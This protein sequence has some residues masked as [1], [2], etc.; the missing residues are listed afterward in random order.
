M[1]QLLL[2][3][4]C[5]HFWPWIGSSAQELDPNGKNVCKATSLSAGLVCCPGWK[6]EGRECTAALC[7]REDACKVD[8]VCVRP[9]ICLCKPGFFG[10][11]CNSRC[12]DQ[13]W[14][15]DCKKS[16]SCHPN[17]KCDPVSGQCTCNANRWGVLCEFP[18]QCAPHGHCNPHSGACHCEPGWWGPNCKKQCLCRVTGS[19]CDPVTGQCVCTQG[20]WGRRCSF[21]CTCH[22]SPCA[23]DS[24]KCECRAGFWGPL[25][26]HHC[27][28][29]HGNCN[30]LDGH[31]SCNP[32]YQGRSCGDPCPAGYYGSQCR[33]SCGHCKRSQPCSPVDGFCLACD[34]GWNGTLCK[35]L[36][37][38][39]Y[40]G[41]NCAQMCPSCRK[42]ETCHPETGAC[43]NC[44]PGK[45]GP[46]CEASCPAGTFGDGCQ[47]TCPDCVNGSCDPVS[48]ECIC[49][50]GYWG[51]SCNETCPEGLF[52]ANC[53][54]FCQCPRGP[55]H[56]HSGDCVLRLKHQGALIAG[57]LIPLLLLL[58]CVTCC[59]CCCGTSQLDAR[60]RMAVADGDA[61]SRMKHHVQGVLAN[62]SSMLPCFSL[63][64]YKLPRVTVSHHDT[65][66][67]FNPSF[68]EP[69]S[70]AWAS[71]SSF[72]SSFDTDDEDPAYCVP[73]RE[74]VPAVAGFELQ[75]GSSKCH[76][77]PDASAFNSEDV[78][79]PFTIPRTS[80]IARA[81]R[82]SVSFAE[83]TKFGPQCQR[84]SM[85]TPNT[86]RKP[87]A[88]CG[89]TKLPPRQHLA[90]PEEGPQQGG[91]PG[92]C[93]ENPEPISE[94]EASHRPS[95]RGTPGGHRM[96]V[97]SGRHVAQRVEALEAALNPNTLDVRG[98]EQNLTT[99]YVTVGTAG[100]SS[101]P[102]ESA[103]GSRE[104]TVQ[105]VL[106]R[107]GSFQR[108]KRAVREEPMVRK[109]TESI[110][111]PPRR[112]LS[113][114]RDSRDMFP[115]P[116]PPH[117]ESSKTTGLEPYE[118]PE[119]L[120]DRHQIDV[121]VKR[122]PL[123]PTSPIFKRQVAQEGE[124]GVTGDSKNSE[125]LE[126]ARSLE[127]NEQ[128]VVEEEPKYEN[129]SPNCYPSDESP[130]I[131]PDC[132]AN[133]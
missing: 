43:L 40:H 97:S 62:L 76:E 45:T 6:Q 70:A 47:F 57:I 14:G 99:I 21:R 88:A 54:S 95:P 103:N 10:A 68:I 60:D 87:K 8:E 4:F 132:E 61:I 34:S 56:P 29:L 117:K 12:P 81:K 26:Q 25:C 128:A 84:G 20:W 86:T 104:G 32:G 36:C 74:D 78:S 30:P 3:L 49:Q 9:G 46:S 77:F 27:D 98:K 33:Y 39:G 91:S 119:L 108:V 73:A 48:G 83:G 89:L 90:D 63:S 15:S 22:L 17:G 105:A 31:C 100:K 120:T 41:E 35:K 5:L 122:E 24:G 18:C 71:D 93:Y 94:A 126:E 118:S 111:K 114:E 101:K 2:L 96:A 129:V 80:S 113:P 55:C 37:T 133:T 16:C 65:E 121:P 112:A 102:N 13:Y 107:L 50:A 66:I 116:A 58:L 67:P 82:P 64:G 131:S 19:R 44:D 72:S 124:D 53:S 92:D 75:E 110:Q 42:G 11:N 79:Q 127:T 69:P 23:Q 115:E 7:E 52:G 28:C 109:S 38:P 106:K 51:T 125:S 59:C 123:I 130:A 1:V 85:E